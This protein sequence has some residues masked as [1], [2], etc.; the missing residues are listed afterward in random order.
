[1]QMPA[2]ESKQNKSKYLK[3]GCDRTGRRVLPG[4]PC[5]PGEN[6]FPQLLM[7]SSLG[8][9]SLAGSAAQ[10]EPNWGVSP[11]PQNTGARAH[12]CWSR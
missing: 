10:I 7:P 11:S 8:H 1:M 5:E 12:G 2:A 6:G 9:G 3:G 4:K